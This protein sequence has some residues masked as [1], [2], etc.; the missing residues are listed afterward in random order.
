[1]P[2]VTVNYRPRSVSKFMIVIF[3]MLLAIPTLIAVLGAAAALIHGDPSVHV[4][5]VLK[6]VLFVGGLCA[7]IVRPAD[8]L[9][10]DHGANLIRHQAGWAKK[11]VAE[12]AIAGLRAVIVQ[13]NPGGSM[14]RLLLAY[15]DG[16]ERPLTEAYYYGSAHHQSVAQALRTAIA[17]QAAR[18]A[19]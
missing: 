12:F 19:F 1:M 16:S 17:A 14:H 10:I 15:Q 6:I 18:V 2:D 11:Q 13:D 7:L 4:G 5:Q 9:T 3:F 8:T